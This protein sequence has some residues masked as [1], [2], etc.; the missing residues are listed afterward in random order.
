MKTDIKPN[1]CYFCGKET[2]LTSDGDRS[3]P[4]CVLYWVSCPNC[5]TEGPLENSASEALKKWNSPF[6]NLKEIDHV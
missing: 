4:F 3:K 1:N 5:Q 2:F 6:A